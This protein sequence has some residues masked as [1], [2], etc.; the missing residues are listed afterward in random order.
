MS[1]EDGTSGGI[2]RFEERAARCAGR[3][4]WVAVAVLFAFFFVREIAATVMEPIWSGLALAG[5]IATVVL[6]VF[7]DR[8]AT[9][10]RKP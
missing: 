9:R 5:L 1:H 6:G 7:V 4:G 10:R 8:R 2:E 3:V